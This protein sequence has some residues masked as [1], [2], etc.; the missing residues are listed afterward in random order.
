[1]SDN[2]RDLLVQ[3]HEGLIE[4]LDD[5]RHELTQ[6]DPDDSRYA[7]VRDRVDEIADRAAA[8]RDEYLES[9]PRV[10]ISR[11]PITGEELVRT[12]DVHGL[13]GPWWDYEGA[14]RPVESGP[15]TFFA[16]TG[17]MRLG[18][19]V[20]DTHF[21]VKPGPG[22]PFVVRRLLERPE[23][24]ATVSSVPVG[25]HEGFAI[26]YF[27]DPIP[28]GIRRH[29]DWGRNRYTA[30]ADDG[31]VGWDEVDEDEGDYDFDL[32]EWIERGKV[33]WIAA[34][35]TS[36]TLREEVDSCPYVGLEGPR[37][38]QRIQYGEV[39]YPGLVGNG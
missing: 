35:D 25:V 23:I 27:A 26:V 16:L 4:A 5:A 36:L 32:R 14:L 6:I 11:C 3:T 21:L 18:E 17:A 29:N 31:R 13:N 37:E 10:P 39:W 1:M 12:I 20:G 15:D 19:P 8:V 34:G 24:V 30:V 7:E 38:I 33:R 28:H 9:L 2:D 22:V